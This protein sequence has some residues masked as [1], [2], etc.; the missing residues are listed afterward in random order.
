MFR[1][2]WVNFGRETN[3]SG[4]QHCSHGIELTGQINYS[5]LGL[6]NLKFLLQCFLLVLVVPQCFSPS[7]FMFLI[8]RTWKFKQ[9]FN[10][11]ASL[12]WPAH[13]ILE[14]QL[15]LTR[16]VPS[17]DA[18]VFILLNTGVSLSLIPALSP[19]YNWCMMIDQQLNFSCFIKCMP[20]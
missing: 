10:C 15:L 13:L 2:F 5:R 3:I 9:V 18:E 4:S 12:R 14:H 6:S 1:D 11:L 20:L 8:S 19:R 17:S 16:D 7:T